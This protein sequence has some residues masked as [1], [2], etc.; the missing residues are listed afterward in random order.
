MGE[1]GESL[2]VRLR[3][4]NCLG[5]DLNNL[6]E[7]EREEALVQLSHHNLG[8]ILIHPTAATSWTSSTHPPAT[9]PSW[10]TINISIKR[11]F[12]V[13]SVIKLTQRQ[14]TKVSSVPSPSTGSL[15][16]PLPPPIDTHT[17]DTM[18]TRKGKVVAKNF[19]SQSPNSR[20]TQSN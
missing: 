13:H 12:K 9:C 5:G 18:T 16:S 10:L 15:R 1:Y 11:Q 14:T 4:L 2:F 8:S 20:G 6:W 7:G 17:R 3:T 19:F